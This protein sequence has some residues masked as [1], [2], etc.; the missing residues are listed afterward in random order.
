MKLSELRKK[1]FLFEDFPEYEEKV[2][3]RLLGQNDRHQG[4]Q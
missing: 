2:C 3:H 1:P 4:Q